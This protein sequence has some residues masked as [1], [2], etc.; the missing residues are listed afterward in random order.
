MPEM[1]LQARLESP[2]RGGSVEIEMF[3]PAMS[4]KEIWMAD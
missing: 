4:K 1:L 2:A 3:I